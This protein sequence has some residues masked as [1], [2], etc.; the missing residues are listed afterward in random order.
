MDYRDDEYLKLFRKIQE[1][2]KPEQS[3]N[4]SGQM[5]KETPNYGSYEDHHGNY[6]IKA[7]NFFNDNMYYNL[8]EVN[9]Q[10]YTIND[11]NIE[12]R[13]NGQNV[14]EV[15][16]YDQQ[17]KLNEI[18][19]H[20]VSEEERISK[21]QKLNEILQKKK[22]EEERLKAEK[23]EAEK[24]NE[25]VNFAESDVISVDMFEKARYNSMMRIANRILP[26]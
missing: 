21:Q 17:R 23:M 11:F 4:F 24:L 15:K 18:M 14:N 6:D 9:V 22:D 26:K 25:V 8:N 1:D 16:K 2:N 3:R 5:L 19:Q 7:N 20:R 12:T 13:I 10:D